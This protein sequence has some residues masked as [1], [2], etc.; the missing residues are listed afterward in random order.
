MG[1]K[2]FIARIIING[3]SNE[4]SS[5]GVRVSIETL[6]DEIKPRVAEKSQF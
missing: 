5:R 3:F 2:K 6:I 4:F 1:Y